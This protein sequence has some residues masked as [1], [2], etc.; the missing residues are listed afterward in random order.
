MVT[1]IDS[2]PSIYQNVV[3]RTKAPGF[4]ADAT[5]RGIGFKLRAVDRYEKHYQ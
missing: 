3:C 4:S 1:T 2:S 5:S